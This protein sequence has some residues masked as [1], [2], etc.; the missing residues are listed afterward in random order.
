MS[1]NASTW[2]YSEPEHDPYLIEERVNQTLWNARQVYLYLDCVQAA[3]PYKMVGEWKDIHIEVEW[4][5]GKHFT[6]RT[7]HEAPGLRRGISQA[8][9]ISPPS[10][11]YQA[12]DGTYVTEW[13]VDGGGER[14]REVQ[15]QPKY[16]QPVR[17]PK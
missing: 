11:A 15:G 16:R 4:E 9:G 14:W 7:D 12:V 10:L 1:T 8:L 13:H 3:P 5:V 6:L 17:H 2:F